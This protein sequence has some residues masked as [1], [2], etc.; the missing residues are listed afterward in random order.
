MKD[1]AKYFREWKFQKYSISMPV[2]EIQKI[3]LTDISDMPRSG[4]R[5]GLLLL[6]TL[7]AALISL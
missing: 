3:R 2:F 5:H 1:T 6:I 4:A 7:P